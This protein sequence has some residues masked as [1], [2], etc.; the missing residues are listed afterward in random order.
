[1]YVF[2][3]RLGQGLSRIAESQQ[4]VGGF[5][6]FWQ[7][8]DRTVDYTLIFQIIG[9]LCVRSRRANHGSAIEFAHGI[10]AIVH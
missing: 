2:C 8:T 1:M 7:P 3:Q 4:F 10:V 6:V 9:N 5:V